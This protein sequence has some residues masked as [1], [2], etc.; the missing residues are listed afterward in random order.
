MKPQNTHWRVEASNET[1][2]VAKAVAAAE[3]EGLL[4]AAQP[5]VAR[6]VHDAP[7]EWYVTLATEKP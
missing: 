4:V 3:S 5:R 6:P 1:E 7:G 2:A